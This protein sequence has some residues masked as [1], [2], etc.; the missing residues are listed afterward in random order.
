SNL[1]ET[2]ARAGRAAEALSVLEGALTVPE[3]APDR[4]IQKAMLSY[5]LADH[6]ISRGL[7]DLDP[8]A[9]FRIRPDLEEAEQHQL[10]AT[11]IDLAEISQSSR[12]RATAAADE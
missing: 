5:A 4:S 10:S 8:H 12:E 3:L 9:L 2:E 11:F 1:L 6:E 7:V